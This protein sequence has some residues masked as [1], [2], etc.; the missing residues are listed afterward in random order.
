M[1]AKVA[2]RRKRQDCTLRSSR[3]EANMKGFSIKRQQSSTSPVHQHDD[4]ISGE[5]R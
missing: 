4:K 2:W 5:Q 3:S 1:T